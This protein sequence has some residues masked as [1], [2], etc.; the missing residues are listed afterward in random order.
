MSPRFA[1]L[2]MPLF[3]VACSLA[4]SI[5]SNPDTGRLGVDAYSSLDADVDL[6]V[7]PDAHM[8]ADAD[9]DIPDAVFPD[10]YVPDAFILDDAFTPPPDVGIDSGP[11][12]TRCNATYGGLFSYAFC[13]ERPTECEF[14]VYL[15][16]STCQTACLS[17]GGACLQAYAYGVPDVCVR[18]PALSCDAIVDGAVCVCTRLP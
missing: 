14:F 5:P 16:A 4:R 18:G 12:R 1:L 6:G 17:G 11:A 9:A 2:G 15:G 10:A 7:V 3:L 8:L 13:D